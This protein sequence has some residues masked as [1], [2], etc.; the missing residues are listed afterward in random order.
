MELI[1]QLIEQ[2]PVVSTILA[3]IGGLRVI[4][5]PIMTAIEAV[6]AATPSPKDNLVVEGIKANVLYKGF[7][8]VLDFFASVKLPKK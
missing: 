8:W 4:F 1:T 5:K 6:V 7:V 2:F 3:V